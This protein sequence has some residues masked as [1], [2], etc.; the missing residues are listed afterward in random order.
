MKSTIQIEFDWLGLKEGLYFCDSV[1]LA[2]Q[3]DTGCDG[4]WWL[5]LTGADGV[6]EA[7]ET[8]VSSWAVMGRRGLCLRITAVM[9]C[10]RQRKNNILKESIKMRLKRWMCCYAIGQWGQVT[11]AAD[12]TVDNFQT[13]T[14]R[15][16]TCMRG[17]TDLEVREKI[18]TKCSWE[19]IGLH[20]MCRNIF[21]CY[22][23]VN[24]L[25]N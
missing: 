1:L 7:N 5:C 8:L 25:E 19:Y 22:N 10:Q 23:H 4:G 21:I 16:V 3:S 18:R 2:L 15:Y 20:T 9:K 11:R 17:V 24:L 13:V 6:A 12:N 14:L